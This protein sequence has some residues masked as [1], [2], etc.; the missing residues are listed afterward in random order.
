MKVPDVWNRTLCLVAMKWREKTP[1]LL[2][3]EEGTIVPLIFFLCFLLRNAF[4]KQRGKNTKETFKVVDYDPKLLVRERKS[5]LL[6]SGV[7][8]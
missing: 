4:N 1:S 2:K 8:F 3:K 5:T 7:I 6:S